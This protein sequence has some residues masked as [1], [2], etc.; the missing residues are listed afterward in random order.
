MTVLNCC[1][2]SQKEIEYFVTIFS[3]HKC[4]EYLKINKFE[5]IENH[6][7]WHAIQSISIIYLHYN[8]ISIRNIFELIQKNSYNQPKTIMNNHRRGEILRIKAIILSLE[9][10]PIVILSKWKIQARAV[11]IF[12][13]NIRSRAAIL[14]SSLFVWILRSRLGNVPHPMALHEQAYVS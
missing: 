14:H 7:F 6:F 2:L 5:N 1:N 10:Y 9:I 11:W 13:V 3:T 8:P 4:W 12:S